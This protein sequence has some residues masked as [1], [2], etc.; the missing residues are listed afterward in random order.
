MQN[1]RLATWPCRSARRGQHFEGV[2]FVKVR[3]PPPH[4][5]RSGQASIAKSEAVA[6]SD[7]MWRRYF[8]DPHKGKAPHH[9]N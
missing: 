7:F 1:M 8:V 3:T 9:F 6:T 4:V 2:A 5:L